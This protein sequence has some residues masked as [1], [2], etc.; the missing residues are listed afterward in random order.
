MRIK[1]IPI[2][3]LASVL[4]PVLFG[5]VHAAVE[6]GPY[7]IYGGVNTEMTVL[8]QLDNLQSCTIKWGENT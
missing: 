8:W 4:P 3:V 5:A 6:K 1:L 2:I 7:L